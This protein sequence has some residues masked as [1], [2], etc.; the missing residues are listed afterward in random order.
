MKR[1]AM[2][3]TALSPPAR[4]AS[5]EPL[6]CSLLQPNLPTTLCSG[7]DLPPHSKATDRSVLTL[8]ARRGPKEQ[9]KSQAA[10]TAE[11]VVSISKKDSPS[12]S[13]PLL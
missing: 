1:R 5:E 12:S 10:N 13:P 6:M 7:L 11:A 4:R 9:Q 3:H 8:P 2:A